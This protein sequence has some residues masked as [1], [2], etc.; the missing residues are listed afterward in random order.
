MDS[1]TG[2]KGITALKSNAIEGHEGAMRPFDV[3]MVLHVCFD[4]EFDFVKA[5]SIHVCLCWYR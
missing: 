3:E 1:V 5:L 4:V 2:L